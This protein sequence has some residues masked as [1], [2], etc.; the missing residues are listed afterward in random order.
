MIGYRSIAVCTDGSASPTPGLAEA[1]ALL[2]PS[3]TLRLVHVTR[4]VPLA[5]AGT[6]A[7]GAGAD[8]PVEGARAE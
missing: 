3:G 8:D 2:A 6:A 4:R 5:A 1:R 7:P